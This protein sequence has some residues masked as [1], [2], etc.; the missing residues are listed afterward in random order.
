[1]PL[2]KLY[3]LR[4]KVGVTECTM[5]GPIG[6]LHGS[7]R[8][9]LVPDIEDSLRMTL[10]LMDPTRPARQQKGAL[11]RTGRDGIR[12]VVLAFRVGWSVRGVRT[13]RDGSVRLGNKLDGAQLGMTT[14]HTAREGCRP[15]EVG[16]Y[17]LSWADDRSR[18]DVT[19]IDDPCSERADRMV[20][21]GLPPVES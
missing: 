18:I 8:Q 19:L 10:G 9:P 11:L 6:L 2:R 4:R 3:G 7:I 13:S 1:M 21:R 5:Q 20:N 16:R 14:S 15:G 17:W 12:A